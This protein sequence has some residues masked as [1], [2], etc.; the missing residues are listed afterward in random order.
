MGGE[1]DII[2]ITEFLI[3]TYCLT[4]F[5]YGFVFEFL[6]SDFFLYLLFIL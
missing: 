1:T 2:K 5:T 6:F 3:L 4:N